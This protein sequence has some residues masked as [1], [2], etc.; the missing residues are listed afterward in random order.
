MQAAVDTT[1]WVLDTWPS[2]NEAAR[3]FC[4]EG[5]R[6]QSATPAQVQAMVAATRP[7]TEAMLGN[8]VAGPIVKQ[9]EALAENVEPEA[10]LAHCG[11]RTDDEELQQLDGTYTFTAARP[12]HERR[13]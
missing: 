8:Q 2:D 6:I 1:S 5:G 4:E 13:E 9:I 12:R 3:T 10:P 7:V 11:A